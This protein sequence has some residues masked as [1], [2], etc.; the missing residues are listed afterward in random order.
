MA[1]ELVQCL[2]E[3]KKKGEKRGTKI[4]RLGHKAI[5]YGFWS[6]DDWPHFFG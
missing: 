3:E 5:K 1:R 6:Y 4:I 2:N